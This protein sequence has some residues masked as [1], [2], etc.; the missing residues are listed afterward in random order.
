MLERVVKRAR[1]ARRVALTAVVTSTKPGDDVIANL[2]AKQGIACFR[3]SEL[4]VLDRYYQAATEFAADSI[5]RVTADCPFVD[6]LIIDRVIDVFCR[7]D[8]DYASNT[9]ERSYPV[10]LD[11]EV[12]SAGALTEAMH[13]AVKEH[14]RTHVTPYIYQHPSRFNLQNV[15]LRS[16][17]DYSHYRLTVDEEQDLV[18]TRI[19]YQT[20]GCRDNF[21]WRDVVKVVKNDPGLMAINQMVKHKGL[22]EG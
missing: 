9:I 11:V 12:F 21:G 22:Y 20:L 8:V 15:R 6:P 14:E 17:S 16:E 18:L 5:V 13:N 3:G 4:D 19:L 1:R 7:G 2:C 10:G